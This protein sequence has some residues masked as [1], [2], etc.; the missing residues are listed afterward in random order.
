MN[1][2]VH[3]LRVSGVNVNLNVAESLSTTDVVLNEEISVYQCSIAVWAFP[4]L[5]QG[6]REGY[7]GLKRRIIGRPEMG[8]F[9]KKMPHHKIMGAWVDSLGI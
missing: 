8:L 4:L 9:L 6:W 5:I 3:S 2:H 7:V 1:D